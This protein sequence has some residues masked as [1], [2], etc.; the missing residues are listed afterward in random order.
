M[1]ILFPYKDFKYNK[2]SLPELGIVV[3]FKNTNA[4]LLGNL[5]KTIQKDIAKNIE[6]GKQKNISEYYHSMTDS[7]LDPN[8]FEK[9][10]SEFIFST[11]EKTMLLV[12]DG[13]EWTLKK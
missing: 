5:S 2:T 4:Y 10:N 7:K 8:L 1:E 9:I 11:N 3:R 12:S 6:V 13:E